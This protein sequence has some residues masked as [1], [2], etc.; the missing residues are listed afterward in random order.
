MRSLTSRPES[1]T[2]RPK[3][4]RAKSP[5][6]AYRALAREVEL[7]PKQAKGRGLFKV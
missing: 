5:K 7:D 6:L 2:S 4:P 1:L 3:G